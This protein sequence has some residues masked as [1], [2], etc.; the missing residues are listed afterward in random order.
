M[1]ADKT[2]FV[3]DSKKNTYAV[4]RTVGPA[5]LF[6]IHQYFS[7][8]DAEPVRM[9]SF[10][11]GRKNNTTNYEALVDRPDDYSNKYQNVNCAG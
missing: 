1:G 9:T 4:R 10:R 7:K 8:A 3:E 5:R 2:M 6:D 11:T